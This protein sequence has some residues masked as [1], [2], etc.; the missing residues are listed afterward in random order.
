MNKDE[1]K[2]YLKDNPIHIKEILES[3]SCHHVRISSKRISSALPDGDNLT[4]INIKL[5]D[6]LST[7]VYTRKEFENYEVQDFLSLVQFLKECSLNEAIGLICKSCNIEYNTHEKKS[8]KSNSYDFLK[9]Y[10]RSLNKTNYIEEYEEIPIDEDIKYRFV[11]CACEL[12]LDDNIDYDS[13][14]K[15]GVCY[16]VLDNRVVF[17]IRSDKDGSIITFKGR[18][19]DDEYKQKGIPKYLYYYPF[20]G[21]F[22]LYGLWENYYDILNSDD[23][24]VCEAEKSVQQADSFGVNN[25]VAISKKTLS[26]YQV[27]KLIKLGKNV[28]LMF[29]KDVTLEEIYCECRK[30]RGLVNVYYVIDNIEILHNKQSPFDCGYEVFNRLY[31]ECKYKFEE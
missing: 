1:L 7:T 9:Q 12:F 17:P 8:V 3:L 31:T 20:K 19:N 29:D 27:H 30:F 2:I 15:F 4:S 22:Y 14:Y 10:K 6:S 13:Q 5:N 25:I 21:E 18:T 26:Q 16:D 28:V 11:Q 24:I 23:I